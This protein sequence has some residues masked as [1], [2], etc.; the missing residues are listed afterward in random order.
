MFEIG[1]NRGRQPRQER[2]EAARTWLG[3]AAGGGERLARI[4]RVGQTE[5]AAELEAEVAELRAKLDTVEDELWALRRPG[6]SNAVAERGAETPLADLPRV[7]L[8]REPDYRLSRCEGFAVYAGSRTLGV[9][10]GVRYRSR[11]DRPDVLEVRGGR[12]GR[13]LLLVPV[14]E[15]EAID[16]DGEAVIVTEACGP[17]QGRE[18]LR[19]YAGE[20]FRRRA[21][22]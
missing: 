6:G 9:V 7:H 16:S 22:L 17:P 12:L 4:F 1:S 3:G 8:P 18:R 5:R 10:E 19:A 15:I 13:R 2:E 14:S 21:R 20:L 11:T